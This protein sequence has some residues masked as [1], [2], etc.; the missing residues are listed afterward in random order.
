MS[1]GSGEVAEKLVDIVVSVVVDTVGRCRR[2]LST[3]LTGDVRMAAAPRDWVT[4]VDK[5]KYGCQS[6]FNY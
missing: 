3:V 4:G 5:F 2:P 6:V 1:R